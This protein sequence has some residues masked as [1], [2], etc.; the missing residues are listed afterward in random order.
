MKVSVI[1]A[2]GYAG[3]ELLRLLLDHPS[4]EIESVTSKRYA[5]EPVYRVHPNL[6]GITSLKFDTNSP[7]HLQSSDVVFSALPHGK[8]SAT[9]SSLI[10]QG[11]KVVDLSAD[12]RLKNP[13]DYETYYGYKHD[14][15]S[16]LGK[17]VYGLPELHRDE[18]K[19]AELVSVPGCMATA[20]ILALAPLVREQLVE[21]TRII[22]DSKIGSSGAGVSPTLASHHSERSEGVRPYKATSHRHIAEIEQELSS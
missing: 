8:S 10:V 2:S 17:S 5:G 16:L 14:Q 20:S 3:G 7:D 18:I 22:V 21:P 9:V 4:C 13:T 11:K 12:F 6:R 15:T 19:K 1:G